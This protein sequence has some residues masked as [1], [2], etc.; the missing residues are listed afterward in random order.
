MPFQ[1][2]GGER[3]DQSQSSACHL[4]THPTPS[5]IK[6]T[7]HSGTEVVTSDSTLIKMLY[8]QWRFSNKILRVWILFWVRLEMKYHCTVICTCVEYLRIISIWLTEINKDTMQK[9][10]FCSAC[11]IY[12]R[13]IFMPWNINLGQFALRFV[14]PSPP[15][16]TPNYGPLGCLYFTLKDNGALLD[17]Q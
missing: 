13:Y 7:W 8:G 3:T 5:H 15:S 11:R 10:S 2:G 4:S 6:L 9:V 1:L 14:P 17:K 12:S 16:P